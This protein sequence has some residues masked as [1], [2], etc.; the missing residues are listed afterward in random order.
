MERLNSEI[1]IRQDARGEQYDLVVIV[2]V[3]GFDDK[4]SVV[5][6]HGKRLASQLEKRDLGTVY[7]YDEALN[8]F[9]EAVRNC[10][11][12]RY[13]FIQPDK[14]INIPAFNNVMQLIETSEK[15]SRETVRRLQV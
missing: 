2:D 11:F 15:Q 13:A 7:E 5:A 12:A 9:N 1:L 4:F 3:L 6:H 8:L 14:N 10:L